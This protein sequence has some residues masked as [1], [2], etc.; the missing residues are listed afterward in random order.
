M[1]TPSPPTSLPI[2]FPSIGEIGGTNP[3]VV[4]GPNGVGKS[5]LMRRLA[6][7]AQRF[8]SAQRRTYLEEQIP[9]TRAEQAKQQI[10]NQLNHAHTNPWQWSNEIDMMFGRILQEHYAALDANNEAAKK[11]EAAKAIVADTTMDRLKT[12]WQAV[13]VN[14][15]LSFSDFSPTVQRTEATGQQSYPA[16]TMSDGERSCLYLAARVLTA[17]PGILVV[18]EPELH[19]HR[20]LAIDYWNKLEE[21]RKDV[22][23]VYVTHELHFGLSRCAPVFLVVRDEGTIE[24]AA[25][26]V[27][28]PNLAEAMLGAATLTIN[29]KRIIFFEGTSGHGLAHG[30]FKRWIVGGKSAALGVGSR[31]SVLD[32][33]Y[34]FSQLG[35]VSNAQVLAVVDRDHGPEGWLSALKP[36]AFVLALHEIESLFAIPEVIR[37]VA[38]HVG[39][40]KDDPWESFLDRAR[41][42]L[43]ATMSKTVAERVRAR[44][45]VLLDGVFDSAQ[46][47][48][49]VV[50]TKNAH[51][52]TF[53]SIDW[54]RSVRALF[55]EE[56]TR[57]R[58]AM[59]KN[60]HSILVIFSGKQ[61]L[62][63]A[64]TVLGLSRERYADIVFEAIEVG[65]HTQHDRIIAALSEFLPARE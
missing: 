37:A 35:V 15:E 47:K 14:R 31:R 63:I 22:R 62:T 32:A 49:T 19:M 23:F 28:P 38:S 3:I 65:K 61:A 43:E 56:E 20:K 29:A 24:K 39:Y 59:G 64:A 30:L 41:K 58:A 16:K 44:I 12:F 18:D 45:G 9:A 5:R 17:D 57:I 36:P 60:D 4:I 13:F 52:E 26:D 8:V 48:A 27:L 50:D 40:S 51:A 25:I 11:G 46:I 42:E 34:T 2:T 21:M 10:S 6:G 55:E 54:P 33:G 1:N 7:S 53:T